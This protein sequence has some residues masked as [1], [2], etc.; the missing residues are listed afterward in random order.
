MRSHGSAELVAPGPRSHR[1]C[2]L[3][4]GS[5]NAK[6]FSIGKFYLSSFRRK[7]ES[8]FIFRASSW[9]PTVVGVTNEGGPM[10]KLR[11][12]MLSA[13]CLNCRSKNMALTSTPKFHNEAGVPAIQIGTK[14][15]ECIGAKP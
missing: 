15:F 14:E 4:H 7:P 6:G 3:C 13:P 9:T 8:S 11:R 2:S 5:R 1:Q 10:D 12:A